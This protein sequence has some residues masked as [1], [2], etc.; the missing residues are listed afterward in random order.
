VHFSQSQRV[1]RGILKGRVVD[2]K[3]DFTEIKIDPTMI[4]E[5]EHGTGDVIFGQFLSKRIESFF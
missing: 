3:I 5:I 1:A 4:I 2:G